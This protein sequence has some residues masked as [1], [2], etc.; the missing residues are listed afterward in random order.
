MNTSPVNVK[1]VS[2]GTVSDCVSIVKPVVFRP[3]RMDMIGDLVAGGGDF[4]FGLSNSFA[5]FLGT[6]IWPEAYEL[7]LLSLTA[8]VVD[9]SWVCIN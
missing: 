6:L 3:P 2:V 7:S 5:L 8:M 1:V 4:A 9:V